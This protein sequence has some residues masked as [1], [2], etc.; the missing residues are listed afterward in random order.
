MMLQILIFIFIGVALGIVTGLTPGIHI[1]LISVMIISMSAFLLPR[2]PAL[3]LV[4]AIISM[5]VT[6]TFLDTIPAVFLGAPEAETALSV[7]PGH[8]LLLEGH[9]YKAVKLT[10][11]GSLLGLLFSIG[12]APLLIYVVDF[13][14]PLLKPLIGYILLGVVVFMV[15]RDKQRK[16]ALLLFVLA[17]VLGLIVLNMPNLSNP[18]FPLLS[19]L[20]GVSTL[21]ISLKDKVNIPPQKVDKE[22][23]IEKSKVLTA[24]GA[25]TFA[26]FL[27]SL[28][29]GLGPAQGAVIATQIIKITNESF[30][31]VIGAI[32]T[33]NFVL[34]LVT[35][36]VLEKARNGA[37]IAVS[38]LIKPDLN[39][40]IIIFIS[41]LI[42]AG[43]VTILALK[44]SS[45]FSKLI[46]KVNYKAMVLGII[47][48]ICV[49]SVVLSGW[50]GFF[51]LIVA[52]GLGLLAPLKDI[53]RNH[54][55]GVLLMPVILYFLL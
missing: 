31:I 36:Y 34:S 47:V 48:L 28:F 19:G 26:G 42:V 14:Y 3:L 1:N 16:W 33:V 51:V 8:K 49:L 18:L 21:V 41:V 23:K 40:I 6:H 38:Q 44:L 5:A 50:I 10:V 29:P 13:I 30:L 27:T 20:F 9:G 2:F 11:M 54:S 39:I 15:L 7:L 52:S 4:I 45:G 32:S 25:G 43:I 55:M 46:C 35:L 24:A 22:L 37:I 53:A 17:G 12:L